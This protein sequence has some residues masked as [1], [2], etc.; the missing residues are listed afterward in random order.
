[1]PGE[2][3]AD[4][5]RGATGLSSVVSGDPGAGDR[6]ERLAAI[7]RQVCRI[8]CGERLLGTGFLIGSDLV[9]TADHVLSP[10][11]DGSVSLSEITFRFD[12]TTG[13]RKKIVT[14][15][16]LSASATPCD[17]TPSSITCCCGWPVRPGYSRSAAP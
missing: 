16:I 17:A 10:L 7:E 12:L 3:S 13:S 9:L 11:W 4:P 15:G 5:G 6:A 8:E 1:M 14:E 2:S